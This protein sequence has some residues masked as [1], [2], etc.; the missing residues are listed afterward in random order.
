MFFCFALFLVF[1]SSGKCTELFVPSCVSQ[2]RTK[3]W[4]VFVACHCA[5]TIGHNASSLSESSPSPSSSQWTPQRPWQSPPMWF[6]AVS[7]IMNTD[8]A[9]HQTCTATIAIDTGVVHQRHHHDDRRWSHPSDIDKAISVTTIATD[10][11]EPTVSLEMGTLTITLTLGG[12]RRSLATAPEAVPSGPGQA[13][14]HATKKLLQ[15]APSFTWLCHTVACQHI[16][17]SLTELCH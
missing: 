17:R 4:Y 16:G 11:N 8:I 12:R 2:A 13:G 5:P 1:L 3:S 6:T 10:N 14:W 15:G 7:S 9:N